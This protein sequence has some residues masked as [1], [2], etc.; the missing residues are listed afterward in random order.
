MRLAAPLGWLALVQGLRGLL[1]PASLRSRSGR[2]VVSIYRGDSF[3][4]DSSIR[5]KVKEIRQL[6]QLDQLSTYELKAQITARS[7]NSK[8]LYE[9]IE[10]ID[11][12]AYLIGTYILNTNQ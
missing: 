8:G 11:Y 4:A 10:L 1:P 9:K 3:E 6:Y 5:I 2:I 7:G 12:L